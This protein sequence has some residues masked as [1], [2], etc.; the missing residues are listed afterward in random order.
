MCLTNYVNVS[1]IIKCSQKTRLYSFGCLPKIPSALHKIICCG[2]VLESSR[3]DDSNTHPQHMFLWRIIENYHCLS[4]HCNP[5]FPLFLL[6]VRCKSGATFVR[7]CFRDADCKS[8][9]RFSRESQMDIINR[10]IA[11]KG[12]RRR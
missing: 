6:Y 8:R 10:T 3:R 1:V 7:K 5:R 2:C 11:Q 4:F 9:R 12:L